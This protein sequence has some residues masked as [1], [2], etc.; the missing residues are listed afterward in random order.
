MEVEVTFII[1]GQFV[2]NADRA[3]NLHQLLKAE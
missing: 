2:M 1:T 3:P